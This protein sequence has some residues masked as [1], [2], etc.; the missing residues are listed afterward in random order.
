MPRRRLAAL[1]LVSALALGACGDRGEETPEAA[2]APDRPQILD[3]RASGH[4]R[5]AKLTAARSVHPGIVQLRFRNAARG[6]HT[7]QIIGAGEGHT[8]A[9]ALRAGQAWG[10]RGEALPDW[11]RFVG[12]TGS[13]P[14][15]RQ[16]SVTTILEPGTYA[17]TDIEGSGPDAAAEFR[18]TGERVEA[19]LQATTA[20]IAAREYAF[21]A[22][23]LRPGRQRVLFENA[24]QEPHHLIALPLRPG[25]NL[26][27]VKRYLG[28]ERG[29]APVDERRAISTAILDG[30]SRQVVELDLVKGTYAMLCFVPDRKG[31]EPH[32]L[33]GM[34]SE[35]TVE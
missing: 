18:V 13:V 25:R 26:D 11:V 29:A 21:E 24:G 35:A 8:I 27:D 7:A 20:R 33:K 10:E 5:A 12:G 31:G 32:A 6:E 15:G 22:E 30:G 1:V 9:Q 19:E 3:V 4:A 28:R 17:V 34:V 16:A 14:A 2:G 23:A